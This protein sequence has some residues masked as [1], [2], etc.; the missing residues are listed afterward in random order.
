MENRK[1]GRNGARVRLVRLGI[2]ALL[3]LLLVLI[4]LSLVILPDQL[5]SSFLPPDPLEE[6]RGN[7]SAALTGPGP[8]RAAH[9][10]SGLQSGADPTSSGRP[11]SQ[12]TG[13][14]LSVRDGAERA[15]SGQAVTGV[16]VPSWI[17]KFLIIWPPA[18]SLNSP[19]LRL[20]VYRSFLRDYRAPHKSQ[21]LRIYS[22]RLSCIF[23][24]GLMET[25]DETGAPWAAC[26]GAISLPTNR[27]RACVRRGACASPRELRA[28]RRTGNTGR[29][30]RPPA[31][32]PVRD[33]LRRLPPAPRGVRAVLS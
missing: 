26:D 2:F 6:L 13:H 10:F 3:A 21:A 18:K 20:F 23:S 15:R 11:D 30:R 9:P 19:E 25:A 8:G 27:R 33:S 7:H 29:R 28:V 1:L 22:F 5:G 31:V 4:P 14:F 16:L 24:C 12:E 17:L 32:L